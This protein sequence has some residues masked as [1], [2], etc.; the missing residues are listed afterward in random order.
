MAGP[1]QCRAGEDAQT[2]SQPLFNN[3]RMIEKRGPTHNSANV[4]SFLFLRNDFLFWE[5]HKVPKR[6]Q[7][8]IEK[9]SVVFPPTTD[10]H[11]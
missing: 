7:K 5:I 2:P 3:Q 6:K 4:K 11:P 8:E 9:L 10:N 1:A